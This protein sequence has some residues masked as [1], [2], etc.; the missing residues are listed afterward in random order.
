MNLIQALVS[1]GAKLNVKNDTGGTALH[2][3]VFWNHKDVVELLVE[4]GASMDEKNDR[5]RTPLDLSGM[6]GHKAIAEYL[7]KKSG[8][9]MPE[10]QEKKRVTKMMDTPM[11]PPTPEKLK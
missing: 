11:E 2:L 5:G 6:Y 4:E 9:K 1:K 8:Q 3:A 7:C 10:M